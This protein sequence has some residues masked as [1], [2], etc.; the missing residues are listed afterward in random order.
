MIELIRNGDILEIPITSIRGIRIMYIVVMRFYD[1][2]HLA[3][4]ICSF[5]KCARSQG[6][7]C[8]H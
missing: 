4:G 3:T 6:H 7:S 1:S 2:I 8:S 5:W